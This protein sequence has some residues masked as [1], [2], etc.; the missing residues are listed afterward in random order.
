MVQ[1]MEEHMLKTNLGRS[2]LLA[3]ALAGVALVSGPV[4][5]HAATSETC[6]AVAEDAARDVHPRRGFIGGLV[7]LPFETVSG[8]TTGRTSHGFAWKQA[9]DA[10]YA[11]CMAGRTVAVETRDESVAGLMVVRPKRG[12]DA[13]CAAKYRSYDPATGTYVTYSGEVVP[14]R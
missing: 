9:Y 14:C 10:A 1:T 5:G 4:P 12:W 2:V 13:Y 6:Q 11:D 8:V 7:L 3:S